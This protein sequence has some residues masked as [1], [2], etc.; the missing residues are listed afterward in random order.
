MQGTT[1]VPVRRTVTVRLSPDEAF[2][3]F[4]NGIDE[5]WPLG[6][7]SVGEERAESVTFEAGVGGRIY[8]VVDG[9]E[10]HEW[11][12]VLEWD[13]PGRVVFSWYPGRDDTTA[14]QVQV[15]FTPAGDG[16][17][18]ELVHT[19][20]ETLGDRASEVRANYDSADGWDMV[21]EA[22]VRSVATGP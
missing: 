1:V 10:E 13:P 18:L 9:G 20:W 15:T 17:T 8:E 14:Q 6:T 3:L 19:G 5:W 22:L 7:H 4:T 11:G 16:T 21:L 12:R 2:R